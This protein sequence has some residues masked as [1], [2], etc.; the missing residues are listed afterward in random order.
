[1]YDL[2]IRMNHWQHKHWEKGFDEGSQWGMDT[3]AWSIETMILDGMSL[4]EAYG[5]T[6]AIYVNKKNLQNRLE[7]WKE[8]NV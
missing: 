3:F 7:A 1:M 4:E 8:L 6:K 5:T 2:F